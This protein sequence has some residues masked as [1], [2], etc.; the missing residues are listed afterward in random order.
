MPQVISIRR[1]EKSN[2]C[3]ILKMMDNAI[4]EIENLEKL[5]VEE[6]R[7]RAVSR[8]IKWTK[9]ILLERLHKA[10]AKDTKKISVTEMVE[11]TEISGQQ[12]EDNQKEDDEEDASNTSSEDDAVLD[13]QL[14]YNFSTE[15]KTELKKSGLKTTGKKDELFERLREAIE[16]KSVSED[17]EQKKTGAMTHRRR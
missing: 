4:S 11:I 13:V 1:L 15:L 16:A 12:R 3:E 6:L 8:S 9:A 17:I 5:E 10:V 2:I 7:K 14:M